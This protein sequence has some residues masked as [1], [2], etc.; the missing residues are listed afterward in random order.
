MPR[1]SSIDRLFEKFQ[2]WRDGG[3]ALLTKVSGVI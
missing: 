1:P 3:L 2:A